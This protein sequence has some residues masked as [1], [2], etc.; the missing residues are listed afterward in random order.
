MQRD[1]RPSFTCFLVHT[2]TFLPRSS[3]VTHEKND[4]CSF[5]KTKAVGWFTILREARL[6]CLPNVYYKNFKNY[7]DYKAY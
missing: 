3:F 6:P 1:V 2:V 5:L 4:K 7:F